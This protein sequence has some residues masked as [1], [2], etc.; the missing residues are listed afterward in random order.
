M[1]YTLTFLSLLVTTVGLMVLTMHAGIRKHRR[2]HLAR[3]L[4]TVALL[5]ATVVFA[6]L[7]SKYERLLPER[8]M[9]IHRI[10]SMTV[11]VA[12]PAVAIT[13]ILLW[14]DARW[15]R[16]HRWCVGLLVTATAA[17]FGT[18]MWVLFLSTAR[19]S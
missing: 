18:G 6:Y 1:I 19:S 17:A 11:A 4:A 9:A 14:R 7:M 16:W 8:E 12:V 15:R 5:C 2:A 10:F 13:G 3:A